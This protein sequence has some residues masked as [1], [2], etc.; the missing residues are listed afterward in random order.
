MKLR[1]FVCDLETEG[2]CFERNLFGDSRP[3]PTSISVGDF[4]LLY[5]FH[6]KTLH[7]LWVAKSQGKMNIVPS[8]WNG[9]YKYQVPVE[10]ASKERISIPSIN[11]KKLFSKL[12]NWYTQNTISGAY[13]DNVLE[14]FA[15]V[16]NIPREKGAVNKIIEEDYRLKYPR[17]YRCDDGH[18]VRSKSECMIDN[19]LSKHRVYHEYERLINVPGMLI[20]DF[21]VYNEKGSPIYIEYWGLMGNPFYQNKRIKKCEIYARYQFPLIEMYESDVRNIDFSLSKELQKNNIQFA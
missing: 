15:F 18:E 11:T 7:G 6:T 12:P 3:W 9:K 1:I 4:C 8:A 17:Q 13:A 5:N 20:P 19:W 14:Y 16:Y 2:E 10:L 21:T